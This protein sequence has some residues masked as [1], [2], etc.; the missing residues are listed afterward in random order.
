M[1]K[2]LHHKPS[3]AEGRSRNRDEDKGNVNRQHE[4]RIPSCSA[5][6]AAKAVTGAAPAPL[7]LFVSSQRKH[8]PGSRKLHL[9]YVV[10]GYN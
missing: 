2:M 6:V 4:E 1:A 7:P 8:S 3:N 9:G 10:S 5:C